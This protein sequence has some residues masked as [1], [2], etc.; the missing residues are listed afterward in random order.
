MPDRNAAAITAALAA[1]A[2]PTAAA[3]P[4]T[5]APTW[6]VEKNSSS[7]RFEG[8]AQDEAFSGSFGKWDAAIHFD[9]ADLGSSQAIV[10]IE[11]ASGGTGDPDKDGPMKEENWLASAMFPTATF[12]SD[13]ISSTGAGAY[14]AEGTLTIRGISQKLSLPFTLAIDGDTAKMQGSV[15]LDRNAFKIGEGAWQDH[16]VDAHVMVKV[17]LT[18]KRGS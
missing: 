18:A 8:V 9:P 3:A 2:L 16:S 10:T 4:A 5:M 17:D 13:T 12:Q 7:L 1:L 6:T 15:T 11:T 14:V